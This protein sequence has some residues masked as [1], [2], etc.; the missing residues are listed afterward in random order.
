MNV[1]LQVFVWIPIFRSFG[2]V[3]GIGLTYLGTA[4]LFLTVAAPFILHSHK[5]AIH[6]GSHFSTFPATLGI[7]CFLSLFYGCPHGCG[8]GSYYGF[9]LHFSN[10]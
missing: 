4:R 1:L 6:K 7:F 8:I 2:Y 10:G 3:P 9:H 5:Q